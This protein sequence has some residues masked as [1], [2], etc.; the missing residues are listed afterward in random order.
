MYEDQFCEFM[1]SY[2]P[3]SKYNAKGKEI[4]ITSDEDMYV[5]YLNVVF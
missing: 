4:E 5:H 1:E 3:K 2:K